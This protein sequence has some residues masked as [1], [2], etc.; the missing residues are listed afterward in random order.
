MTSN[1]YQI[2]ATPVFK[3]TLKKLCT[4]LERKY[5]K[6]KANEAKNAIKLKIAST[7]QTDPYH[8]PVSERLIEFGIP[9]YRQLRIEQHN[10]VFFRVDESKKRVV[11][12]AAMDSRQSIEKLLFETNILL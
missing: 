11:L 12:L 5:G 9:D 10:I 2:L 8:A 3:I 7:L 4:F 6:A 1:N